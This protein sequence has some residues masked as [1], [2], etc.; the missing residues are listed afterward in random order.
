MAIPGQQDPAL[1][2]FEEGL[3]DELCRQHD[4]LDL[5]VASKADE[6]SRR[7]GTLPTTCVTIFG[8]N[9]LIRTPF[10]KYI[11]MAKEVAR[12]DCQQYIHKIPE[13]VRQVRAR[14]ITLWW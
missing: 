2:K 14:T 9:P 7:L 8:A 1:R 12:R 13:A 11:S 10:T 3:Y 4:R 5:F 6:I